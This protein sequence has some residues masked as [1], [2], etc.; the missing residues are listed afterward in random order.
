MTLALN[1]G[2]YNP[3]ARYEKTFMPSAKTQVVDQL[4]GPLT[5]PSA[6]PWAASEL[7]YF[8]AMTYGQ[9]TTVQELPEPF[10]LPP[11][12]SHSAALM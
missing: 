5:S 10:Q 1:C 4:A 3:I 9:Y 7:W 2:R 8:I 12:V 6:A 11:M